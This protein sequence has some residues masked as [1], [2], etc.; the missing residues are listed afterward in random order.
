M[1]DIFNLCAVAS[2]IC[3]FI[4][5]KV[6]KKKKQLQSIQS[7]GTQTSSPVLILDDF[8]HRIS[9]ELSTLQDRME[10]LEQQRLQGVT[11]LRMG[12]ALLTHNKDGSAQSEEPNQEKILWPGARP[13]YLSY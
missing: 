3:I 7:K 12:S 4:L 9:S 6:I 2:L 1:L 13:S 8:I 10:H 5:T 11:T